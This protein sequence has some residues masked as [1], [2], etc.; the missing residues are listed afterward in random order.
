MDGLLLLLFP[1]PQQKIRAFPRRMSHTKQGASGHCKFFNE[2]VNSVWGEFIG[3]LCGQWF[4]LG[5]QLIEIDT[6]LGCKLIYEASLCIPFRMSHDRVLLS[7]WTL[8]ITATPKFW[9]LQMRLQELIQ[10]TNLPLFRAGKRCFAKLKPALACLVVDIVKQF[11]DDLFML[12]K[13]N[14]LQNP[15]KRMSNIHSKLSHGCTH[16]IS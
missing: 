3:K 10:Q 6:L 13:T 12:P 14:L 15:R 7:N 2:L 11:C 1:R 16:S 5:A 8:K 9:L 4:E